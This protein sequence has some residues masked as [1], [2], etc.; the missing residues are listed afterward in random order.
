M[1]SRRT[2]SAIDAIADA[3]FDELSILSPSISLFLGTENPHGFDDYS[4][5]GLKAATDI[6][7]RTLTAVDTGEA[8][9]LATNGLAETDLVTID[10]M[11]ER[12]CTA[13]DL[14][15]A[16]LQHTVLNVI[17]SP[18]QQM[19]DIFDLLP[20]GTSAG[21]KTI[22]ATMAALPRSIAGYRES[23]R[24]ARDQLSRVPAR[25]QIE[26]VAAQSEA[27]SEADNRFSALA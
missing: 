13:T 7:A 24:Y 4:P 6:R 25:L 11:P 5:E 15:E 8:A 17:E 9:G 2:P 14:Y 19:R 23:L 16:R 26:R 21:W 1:T 12:L 10:A 27:L 3:Y 20:T 18:V 22:S